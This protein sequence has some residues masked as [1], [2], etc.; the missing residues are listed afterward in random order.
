MLTVV[1]RILYKQE[2]RFQ[3]F[4]ALKTLLIGIDVSQRNS[5][6]LMEVKLLTC[7]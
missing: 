7:S 4:L 1:K 2:K 5:I 6:C 3:I